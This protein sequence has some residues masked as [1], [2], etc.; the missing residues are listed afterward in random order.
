M[1]VNISGAFGT[2]RLFSVLLDKLFN[3]EGQNT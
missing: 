3:L 1:E 2:L